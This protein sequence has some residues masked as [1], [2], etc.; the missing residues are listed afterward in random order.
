MP[1]FDELIPVVPSPPSPPP[2]GAV[3]PVFDVAA[4]PALSVPPL[5][6]PPPA[7]LLA[8]VKP[9]IATDGNQFDPARLEQLCTELDTASVKEMATDFLKELPDRLT[10]LK[11]LH[12]AQQWPDLERS[13][14]SLKGLTLMFGFSSFSSTF[15]AIEEAA[16]KRDAPAALALLNRLP[17]QSEADM[18][19][20]QHWIQQQNRQAGL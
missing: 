7:W 1:P 2:A 11:R 20:L 10:E 8:A 14:H 15:L 6:P 18:Q 4:V 13:A 12:T 9:V 16:E 19:Q 3:A 5:L 17:P